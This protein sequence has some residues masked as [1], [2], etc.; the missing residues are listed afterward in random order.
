MELK[1]CHCQVM[2][3]DRTLNAHVAGEIRA[4]MARQ[5]ITGRQLAQQL[6][7]SHMWVSYRLTE[8]TPIQ[9]DDLQQIARALEVEITDLLPA[10]ALRDGRSINERYAAAPGGPRAKRLLDR[11]EVSRTSDAE[12][13][14]RVKSA[15]Q[16][17]PRSRPFWTH[18]G[19]TA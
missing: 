1:L 5:R 18:D 3:D 10:P 2:S 12:R 15:G 8:T 11:A 4:S 7:K 13:H 6:G 16:T 19:V 17:G 14:D 9:L